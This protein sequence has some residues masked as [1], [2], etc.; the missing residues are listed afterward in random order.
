MSQP[1]WMSFAWR[2]FGV[3]EIKG[4]R[5][6]T[7]IV[8][9]FRAVGHSKITDDETA[10]CA[11]F[12]GAC[13]ERAGIA[14]TRSLMARSYL[15]WG[16]A[17]K[18]PVP[19]C[20]AVLS[21]GANPK[22]G[23]VGFFL[24]ETKA[25][26]VLLGGNQRDRVGVNK[27]TKTRVL[28]YRWPTG[29]DVVAQ[30]TSSS[31]FERALTHVLEME[32]G[33][34][35]DPQDPGGPT[36]KG[37][38]LAVF[39][40]HRGERIKRKNREQLKDDLRNIP[41]DDVRGIYHKRYWLAARCEDLPGGLAFMHFDAAVNQG[42]GRA[43]RFLQQA[44]GA[45]VDGIVGPRTM[46]AIF[47]SSESHA[48]SAYGKLRERHYRGLK[49]FRRFGRGWLHRL[50][51][52]HSRAVALSKKSAATALPRQSK[53]ETSEMNGN[54]KWW[55]ESLTIW[56]SIITAL[57]TVLPL[58]GPIIGL[59]VSSGMVEEF[60]EQVV[61]LIQAVGGVA[62]TIMAILGRFRAQT[63]LKRRSLS[64]TV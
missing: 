29:V 23:H 61:R 39:A 54:S 18:R 25:G 60:G 63:L 2:D 16:R 41:R 48:I 64:L 42:V 36:N 34:S 9:Y 26:V 37:I 51:A 45:T 57:S 50:A 7:R 11:A 1:S 6:E 31:E 27:Y 28:D 3:K 12:V 62:G 15:K 13:L 14:S 4:R 59:D 24:R 43:I 56:G 44:V 49:H 46:S 52:T 22:L 58:L 38:S 33:W 53:K 47:R 10:W 5:D 32:G 21:R 30:G 55:A 20:I 19:G 17:L 35:D 8:K 40:A